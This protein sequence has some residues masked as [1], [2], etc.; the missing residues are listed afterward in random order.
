MEG[1]LLCPLGG[2]RDRAA[3]SAALGHRHRRENSV[4]GLRHGVEPQLVAACG[5]RPSLS[6]L[7]TLD[8]YVGAQ[9]GRNGWMSVFS[10][11]CIY[12][13]SQ[14]FTIVKNGKWKK[15]ERMEKSG[16][17]GIAGDGYAERGAWEGME[18]RLGGCHLRF[19]S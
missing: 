8:T 5:L 9:S 19:S 12:S 17:R 13:I 7:Y 10:S 1:C 15:M 18:G 3:A 11:L 16:R 4:R 6:S 14:I 2:G